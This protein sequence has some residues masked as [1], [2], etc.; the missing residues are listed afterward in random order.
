[1]STNLIM[2]S[3]ACNIIGPTTY[4][5]LCPSVSDADEFLKECRGK[6]GMKTIL[7]LRVSARSSM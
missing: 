1:M 3:T 6:D 2:L 5:V 4:K 7:V